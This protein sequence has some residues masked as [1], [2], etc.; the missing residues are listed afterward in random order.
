MSEDELLKMSD[1][2]LLD[3]LIAKAVRGRP[4]PFPTDEAYKWKGDFEG[5]HHVLYDLFS[6]ARFLGLR[7]SRPQLHDHMWHLH[8]PCSAKTRRA[9]PTAVL[10][11]GQPA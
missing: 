1:D 8:F 5:L 11:A 3:A 2:E 10:A 4:S 7:F 9:M 6:E